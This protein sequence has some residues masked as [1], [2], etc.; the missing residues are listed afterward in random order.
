MDTQEY[1]ALVEKR[2]SEKEQLE[3]KMP[4][5]AVW[6]YVPFSLQ[7]YAI[8][9]KLPMH[10]IVKLESVRNQPQQ[11]ISNEELLE[12]GISI[13]E[14]TRDIMLNNLVFPKIALEEKEG[15]ILPEQIDP[16]DFEFFMNFVRA[17]GQASANKFR[18]KTS[19]KRR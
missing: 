3:L 14:I 8:S 19:R 5:G 9:G 15:C 12:A 6:L 10:L 17:G 7:Q 16:E 2:K 13:M 11:K 18:P 4:S 1:L